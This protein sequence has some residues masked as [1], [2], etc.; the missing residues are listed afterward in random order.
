MY[1]I[2]KRIEIYS[3]TLSLSND[4]NDNNE[5]QTKVIIYSYKILI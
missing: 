2:C 4:I 3:S 5:S 1:S